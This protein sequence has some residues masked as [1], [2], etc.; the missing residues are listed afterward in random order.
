M[1]DFK[2]DGSISSEVISP[3]EQIYKYSFTWAGDEEQLCV[4]FDL[5]KLSGASVSV[6][7]RRIV[8]HLD[9]SCVR[10]KTC[11]CSETSFRHN[12]LSPLIFES[13]KVV[14]QEEWRCKTENSV[15]TSLEC[16]FF[17]S[18]AFPPDGCL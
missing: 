12:A 11:K 3:A 16:R 18:L 8:R 6:L 1:D 17:P 2:S 10:L 9:S 5:H 13:E 4:H 15:E 14:Y 7:R